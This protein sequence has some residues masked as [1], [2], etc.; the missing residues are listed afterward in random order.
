MPELPEMQ[1]L[2]ERVDAA[3]AGA[4]LVAA[5]PIAFSGLKTVD[6]SPDSLVG[7]AL[8]KAGR[9]GKFLVL[10]FG[11]PRILVHLS[12][13]GRPDLETPPK[14]TR[15]KNGVFR[16]KFDRAPAIFVKEFGHERKA[17]WW[18]LAEG[19]DGPLANLGVEPFDE[20]F[21][22]LIATSDDARRIHTVLRDQRTIAGIGRGYADDLLH[23]AR[24]SPFATLRSMDAESRARLVHAAR[25]VLNEGLAGERTRTG[26]LPPKLGERFKIHG[27]A[28]TP[29]PSCGG[30]LRR[31]SYES[32][33][34]TYCP[35]C[36]TGGRAL[37]DRR[38]SRLLK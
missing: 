12:Q 11:G 24:L 28:G 6:P 4:R 15:P 34:V 23:R 31:I 22:R 26:G 32:H 5:T 21:E 10:D 18:V 19:D 14:T 27:R 3:L 36:Q 16:L 2:S 7:R 29:C 17:G 35:A 1:A 13:A 30:D 37:A 25:E 8:A 33:E 38:M 20:A 9:R